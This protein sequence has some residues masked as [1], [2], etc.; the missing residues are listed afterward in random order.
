MIQ[1]Q[2]K[3]LHASRDILVQ[4]LLALADAGIAFLN[5][6][7]KYSKLPATLPAFEQRTFLRIHLTEPPSREE[8]VGKVAVLLDTIV[9]EKEIPNGIELLQQAVR[10]LAS[11]ITVQILFPDPAD[12]QYVPPTR[13]MKE[14]GGER[15]TSTTPPLSKI[16]RLCMYSRISYAYAMTSL[17]AELD[18]IL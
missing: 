17:I 7:A 4:Q 10:R 11:P 12:L 2:R 14:S 15:L 16:L 1:E 13:M 3:N 6:A 18:I 9:R 8:R 5:S